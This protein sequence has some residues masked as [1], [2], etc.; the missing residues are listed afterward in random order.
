MIALTA[1]FIGLRLVRELTYGLLLAALAWLVLSVLGA[2]VAALPV[3]VAIIIDAM[4]IAESG[5]R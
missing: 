1:A 4:I 3:S 2:A 5:R